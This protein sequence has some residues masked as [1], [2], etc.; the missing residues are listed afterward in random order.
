M[1]KTIEDRLAEHARKAITCTES[2]LSA[3]N[4]I[5]RVVSAEQQAPNQH[6]WSLIEIQCRNDRG[7]STRIG[8]PANQNHDEKRK[9]QPHVPNY[10]K[11]GYRLARAL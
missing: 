9:T 1:Y 2:S 3:S 5:K 10:I 6:I 7:G 8:C 11:R 4:Y